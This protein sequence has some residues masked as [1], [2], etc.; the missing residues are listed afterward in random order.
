MPL[1]KFDFLSSSSNMATKFNG[2]PLPRFEIKPE[3]KSHD[4]DEVT[5]TL[6]SKNVHV[7]WDWKSARL[8]S[9]Y[10]VSTLFTN[11]QQGLQKLDP[12]LTINTVVASGDLYTLDIN[13]T[14]AESRYQILEK[15]DRVMTF[16]VP[17]RLKRSN[18][19]HLSE[20]FYALQ[21]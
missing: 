8:P 13:E 1:P 2:A 14:E 19:Q 18:L 7:V 9:G 4:D 21:P 12:A 16:K 11:I 17:S 10:D 3:A 15:D 5:V 20:K 6:K